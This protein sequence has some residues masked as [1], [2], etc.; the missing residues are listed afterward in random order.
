[1]I[2]SEALDIVLENR[3]GTIWLTLAGHFHN[4]QMPSM[5][6]KFVNL[7]NDGCR[8]FV[9]NM[10]RVQ[11]VESTVVPMFLS[12]LNT[13]KGK[14][15]DIKL[16][17]KNA[18]LEREFK[19]YRNIFS[20]YSDSQMLAKGTFFG[21]IKKRSN[22]LRKK[23]GFRISRTVALFII[24]VLS[25]WFLTLLS[26]IEMQNARLRQQQEELEELGLW[27]VTADIELERMRERLAPLEQLG[28]I[29]REQ[30]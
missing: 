23:T 29:S 25:G 19:P 18:H 17:F 4:D 8:S 28:V 3:D 2:R 11:S 15:G 1:M 16:I 30:Q 27:K 5:R 9:V 13:L 12:L 22:A 26:I 14:G 6:E 10:E 20:I 7:I 21:L 24:I